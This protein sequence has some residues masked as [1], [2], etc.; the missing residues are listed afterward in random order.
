MVVS[1]EQARLRSEV[2]AFELESMFFSRPGSLRVSA[3]DPL[4]VIGS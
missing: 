4:I 1:R 2:A 3:S